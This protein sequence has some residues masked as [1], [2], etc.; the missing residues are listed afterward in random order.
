MMIATQIEDHLSLR[1]VTPVALAHYAQSEGWFKVGVYR[2]YSDIY[3]AEGKHEII[4]PRTDTIDDYEMAVSD[5]IRIFASVLER[6]IKSIYRDLTLADK[7]VLCV[8]ALEA[9]PDGLPF[10]TSYVLLKRTR[11]MLLSA[12]R[13]LTD[14]RR[15]YRGRPSGEVA[16]YLRRVQLGRTEGGS[17]SLIIISPA[18]APRLLPTVLNIE[19]EVAPMERRVAER[20]SESLSATRT[21]TERAARGDAFAF[22]EPA[23][24]GVSANLCESVADLVENVSPFDVSFSWASTRPSTA[25]RGPVKFSHGDVPILREVAGNFRSLEP[26]HNKE[27]SGFVYKLTQHQGQVEGTISIQS[28]VDGASRSVVAVLSQQDYKKAVDAHA[29]KSFVYLKGD[30][31]RS[32]GQFHLRNPR[33]IDIIKP[34]QSQTSFD[35]GID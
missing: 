14:S 20:L 2:G 31:E 29:A 28:N 3:A 23:V 5:L 6:D 26:E 10:E 24:R 19:D 13:S 22:E 30:L 16:N 34:P 4:V 12:A 33:I 1:S 15:V 8:R 11:T 35:F 17:F 21:A 18:I 25:R 27:V 7:D 32:S 9:S